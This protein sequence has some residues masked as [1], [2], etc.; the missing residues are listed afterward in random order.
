MQ[1][2]K[3]NLTAEK[4]YNVNEFP[5]FRDLGSPDDLFLRCGYTE[6]LELTYNQSVY[7]TYTFFFIKNVLRLFF[8]S[9]WQSRTL[10]ILMNCNNCKWWGFHAIYR[11]SYIRYSNKINLE[12]NYS[13]LFLF[14][15]L[16]LFFEC[17]IRIAHRWESRNG[18]D[19]E[20][21][22]EG[23]GRFL[24]VT[25]HYHSW[26]FSSGI[27]KIISFLFFKIVHLFYWP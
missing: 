6:Y 7:G 10:L 24:D 25:L 13:Y 23:S 4:V 9:V 26:W 5:I 1:K 11:I 15:L 20:H 14:S 12:F 3:H 22:C 21:S 16:L 19:K 18:I 2:K 17:S 27:D 8:L